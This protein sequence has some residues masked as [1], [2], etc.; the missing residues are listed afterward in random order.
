MYVYRQTGE[1]WP[2]SGQGRTF[3]ALRNTTTFAL[4]DLEFALELDG[5]SN[6]HGGAPAVATRRAV[7]EFPAGIVGDPTAAGICGMDFV[8]AKE[9]NINRDALPKCRDSAIGWAV[10]DGSYPNGNTIGIQRRRLWR[11]AT[12]PNEAAAFAT[13]ILGLP[14]RM[15]ATVSPSNGYR[16]KVTSDNISQAAAVRMFRAYI[17]GVPADHQGDGGQPPAGNVVWGS[18][19]DCDGNL[20]LTTGVFSCA[21]G[22]I[23]E[24]HR[25]GSP[26]PGAERT[27]FMRNGSVCDEPLDAEFRLGPWGKTWSE[28]AE[29]VPVDGLEDCDEQPFAP[30]FKVTPERPVAGQPSGYTVAIEVPQNGDPDGPATAHVKDVSVTL[31]KGLSISPPSANGLGACTDAQLNLNGDSEPACPVAAS[32][33]SLKIETPVLD[34]PVT[35]RAYLGSQL[36]SRAAVRPASRQPLRPARPIRRL[37]GTPHSRCGRPVRMAIRRSS[38]FSRSACLKGCSATSA[39]CRCVVRRRPPSVHATNPRESAMSRSLR[40][41][42]WIRFGFLRPA[43]ARPV[44]I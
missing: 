31:P 44:C 41:L 5:V 3:L 29:R 24:G 28:I 33:G 10:I 22:G 8:L 9:D 43:R 4:T 6:D 18:D 38:R 20:S 30:T 21:L 39:P 32:I 14:I 25:F 42:A 16:I 35:G 27:V 37:V 15:G 17:W 2:F 26:L 11:V 12:G 34:E 23:F 19:K 7:V 36:S 13:S 40:V 1:G